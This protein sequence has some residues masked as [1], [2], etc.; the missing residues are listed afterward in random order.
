VNI[1]ILDDCQD[2][3]RKLP[4]AERLGPYSAQVYT[5][6]VKG[7]GQLE[8]RLKDADI[9]VLTG[10]RSHITRAL[11]DRLPRLKLIAQAGRVGPH[12]DVAACTKR[13][14]AVAD[15]VSLQVATAEFT[16]ALMLAAMR[17]LP[18]YVAS[19]KQGVWQQSGL[20]SASM[21][22]N[23]GL[24]MLL[25]GKVLG[26][27]GYGRVG[28]L[29][30]G[31]GQ[32]FGMNVRV[33]GR[34]A[35]RAQALADGLQVAATREDFFAACDVLSVH[36][37]LTEETRNSITLDDLSL[38]KPTALFVNTAAAELL[39]PDALAIALGEGRP[40]MAAV[41][42]YE[43]EPI[44][45]GHNLLRLENCLCTPHISSVE[46]ESY[47]IYFGAAFNN[48]L[49]FIHGTPTNIINPEVLTS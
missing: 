25:R 48:V 10:G 37:L 31:Y 38:M 39:E 45:Q 35:S 1:V 43:N 9:V 13:N 41:D 47:E 34:E 16:W 8:R 21:P 7:V 12:I 20:T 46:Q 44:T 18:Q 22:P 5:T 2:A 27:L 40:G 14:V 24:G 33:W 23:F 42:V 15:G 19:L 4:C 6:T 3:V 29:V 32:A 17:R 11:L 26:I 30:A 28:Q 49:N 36:L